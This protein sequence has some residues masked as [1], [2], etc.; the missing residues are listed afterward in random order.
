MCER[1]TYELKL[2]HTPLVL[3]DVLDFLKLIYPLNCM[4]QA[5]FAVYY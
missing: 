5:C 3:F 4:M 1:N 2:T